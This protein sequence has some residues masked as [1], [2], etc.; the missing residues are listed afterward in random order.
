MTC[1]P[2]SSTASPAVKR[3][4]AGV[5]LTMTGYVLAVLG[6]STFVHHHHPNGFEVYLLAAIPSFCIFAMLGVVAIYLRDEKDEYQRMLVVRSILV[7][8]FVIL[9][10]SAFTDFLRS[11]GDLPG[12]PPFAEFVSFWIIFAIAQGVQSIGNRSH[13]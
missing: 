13:E 8:A 6:T 5:A 9:A 11:Y 12:L 4:T 1:N 10:M 3:Y 2:F 7:A